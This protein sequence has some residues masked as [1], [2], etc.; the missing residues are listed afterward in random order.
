MEENNGC[1]ENCS[2]KTK[3]TVETKSKC[4]KNCK[5]KDTIS[6]LKSQLSESNDKYLRLYADLENYKKRSQKEK[7]EL[8]D[9]TKV[10]LISSILDMD[11][12]LHLALKSIKDKDAKKGVS[13][14]V[15]KVETFLK[16]HGI[17]SIQTDNYD[18]DIH[19][20]ITVLKQDSTKIVD[21]VNKG[22]TLNGKPFRFPKI[23]L[24]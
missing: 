23:I 14:I 11:N 13:L 15:S 12:D 20:V 7:E 6:G 8:R 4:G 22:Y 19:E 21:V 9:N 24:G 16:S 1:G 17:E 2:C 3:S 18:S 5:C 10:S